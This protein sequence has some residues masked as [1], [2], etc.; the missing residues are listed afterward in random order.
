[1]WTDE[2]QGSLDWREGD[3]LVSVNATRGAAPSGIHYTN[4]TYASWVAAC[5]LSFPVQCEI[6]WIIVTQVRNRSF[7]VAYWAIALRF[8]VTFASGKYLALLFRA[9]FRPK[10]T[11]YFL[12]FTLE[13]MMRWQTFSAAQHSWATL[14]L[15]ERPNKFP[16]LL[17]RY[18]KGILN[19]YVKGYTLFVLVPILVFSLKIILAH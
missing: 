7:P 18:W 14:S 19:H 17:A 10:N 2:C 8:L 3:S 15:G 6:L 13:R 5:Y 1:M 16:G 11:V 12:H 4:S 9:Q